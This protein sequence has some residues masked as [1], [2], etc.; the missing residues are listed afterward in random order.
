MLQLG[1]LFFLVYVAFL[2]VWFLARGRLSADGAGLGPKLAARRLHGWSRARVGEFVQ[3][4]RSRLPRRRDAKH[5]GVVQRR[6]CEPAGL[7]SRDLARPRRIRAHAVGDA[8]DLR[9]PIRVRSLSMRELESASTAIAA[10]EWEPVPSRGVC[11]RAGSDRR[12]DPT[13]VRTVRERA[14]RGAN[15]AAVLRAVGARGGVTMRELGMATGVKGS[16]LPKLVR[17][18]T[19]RGELEKIV[20]PDGQ[21]G[22]VLARTDARGGEE[23]LDAVQAGEK[24]E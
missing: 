18:L 21:I 3:R 14:P 12:V 20:R 19:L 10:A 6:D 23:P 16:S 11:D 5:A 22:F 2:G 13:S 4:A 24:S 7:L 1:M 15:R 9:W 8:K 17:T